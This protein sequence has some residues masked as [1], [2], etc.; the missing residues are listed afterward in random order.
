[1]VIQILPNNNEKCYMNFSPKI[2][3]TKRGLCLLV[4]IK[5]SEVPG[6]EN[7]KSHSPLIT[8]F[9]TYKKTSARGNPQ[10]TQ[11]YNPSSSEQNK[12]RYRDCCINSQPTKKRET[13]KILTK[14]KILGV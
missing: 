10:I 7:R 1:M 4:Q 8:G 9:S 11:F 6:F 13:L 3:T 12:R 2:F 14:I 5:P